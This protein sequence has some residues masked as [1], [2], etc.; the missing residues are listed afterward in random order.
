MGRGLPTPYPRQHCY[1]VTCPHAVLRAPC[2]ACAHRTPACMRSR[3]RPACLRPMCPCLVRLGSRLPTLQIEALAV[4]RH[5]LVSLSR[6]RPA[7]P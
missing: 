6:M 1:L 2:P 7:T 4:P 3:M 5:R